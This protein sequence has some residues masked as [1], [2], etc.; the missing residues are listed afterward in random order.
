MPVIRKKRA[1]ADGGDPN[2]TSSDPSAATQQEPKAGE[3]AQEGTNAGQS[4]DFGGLSP[5][6]IQAWGEVQQLRGEENG[7]DRTLVFRQ[8]HI[9]LAL[10]L[11]GAIVATVGVI[12]VDETDSTKLTAIISIATAVLGAGAALL[13]TGAAAG[14]AARILSRPVIEKNGPGTVPTPI[15]PKP[16]PAGPRGG[17]RP[18]TA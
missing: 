17:S 14:A 18:V 9:A 6:Q 5:E 7:R 12:L 1:A 15:T 16:T 3:D 2:L 11:G 13:P 10:I 8:L 4:V